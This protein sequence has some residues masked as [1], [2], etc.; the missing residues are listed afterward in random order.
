M[1]SHMRV[2]EDKAYEWLTRVAKVKK[3]YEY[4]VQYL[5]T[6]DGHLYS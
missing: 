4:T 2:T 5:S 6:V 1:T 3:K